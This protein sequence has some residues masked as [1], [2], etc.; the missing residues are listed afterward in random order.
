M[1]TA[2]HSALSKLKIPRNFTFSGGQI[3]KWVLF[4]VKIMRLCT[5]NGKLINFALNWSSHCI[6]NEAFWILHPCNIGNHVLIW[7]TLVQSFYIKTLKT[8]DKSLSWWKYT[9]STSRKMLFQ[10]YWMT[11]TWEFAP[12]KM[13]NFQEFSG[14]WGRCLKCEARKTLIF[15]GSCRL[16]LPVIIS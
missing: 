4:N 3:P 5:Q 9:W 15:L 10:K 14:L 11:P 16:Y 7:S 12:L 6:F 8:Q 13:F 2:G 1:Q